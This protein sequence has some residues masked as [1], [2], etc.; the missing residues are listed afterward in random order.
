M[1]REDLRAKLSG[2]FVAERHARLSAF[3]TGNL[4]AG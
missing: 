4:K 3:K 1:R 2:S